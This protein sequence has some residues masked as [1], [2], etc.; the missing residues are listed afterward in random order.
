MP[1]TRKAWSIVPPWS[2]QSA[3]ASAAAAGA[4]PPDDDRR[5]DD[6]GG[7]DPPALDND[8]DDDDDASRA[9]ER[10]AVAS[11]AATEVRSKVLRNGGTRAEAE[12]AATRT[13]LSFYGEGT[14]GVACIAGGGG[15]VPVPVPVPV[16]VTPLLTNIPVTSSKTPENIYVSDDAAPARPNPIREPDWAAKKKKRKDLLLLVRGERV[17]TWVQCLVELVHGVLA[18]FDLAFEIS[19]GRLPELLRPAD[20]GERFAIGALGADVHRPL[21]ARGPYRRFGRMFA[22]PQPPAPPPGPR[23]GAA[24][25]DVVAY[26]FSRRPTP[27]ARPPAAPIPHPDFGGRGPSVLCGWFANYFLHMFLVADPA[28]LTRQ[29]LGHFSSSSVYGRTEADVSDLRTGE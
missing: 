12:A 28:D 11:A 24:A 8:D 19:A 5:D 23:G 26:V 20:E 6:G 21:S 13:A 3:R 15:S 4:H 10:S 2:R 17:P 9:S 22:R 14:T 7:Y 1:L 27:R 16:P 25:A 18:A 29:R